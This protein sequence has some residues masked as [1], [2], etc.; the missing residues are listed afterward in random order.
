MI[1]SILLI[2]L[3]EGSKHNAGM[4]KDSHMLDDLK[5]HA[6]SPTG[7]VMCVHGDPTYPLR[8]HLQ[9]PFRA[10][11]RGLTPAMELCNKNE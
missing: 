2:R 6:Y 11:A 3:L 10:G 4:L 5:L 1:M 8:A 9:V 7:Q